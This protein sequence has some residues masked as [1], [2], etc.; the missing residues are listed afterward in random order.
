[1]SHAREQ[2]L[3]EHGLGPGARGFETDLAAQVAAQRLIPAEIERFR[4]L[5]GKEA[6]KLFDYCPGARIAPGRILVQ[7]LEAN[8]LE[9]AV[10]LCVP[11]PQ[12]QQLPVTR[13]P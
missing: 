4:G 2:R 8:G 5:A 12:R 3:P 13:L 11:C 9:P 10:D 1:M 6:P 7:T